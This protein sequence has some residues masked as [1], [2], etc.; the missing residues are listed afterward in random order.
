MSLPI[1]NRYFWREISFNIML[2][3]FGLLAMFSFFDLLQELDSLGKGHYGI[4]SM[5]TF[6]GLSIP[7][8]IY[9]VAPVAVLLGIVYTLGAMAGN[10]ELIVMRTSGISLQVIAKILLS[11]GLVFALVT[12]MIG[13]IIAPL[14]EKMAQR[15]RIQA[16]DSVI[17]QDFQS[18][19]WIKDGSSFVNVN[20]VLPDSSLVNIDIYDFDPQFHLRSISHAEKGHFADDH[21]KLL[22]VTQTLF[23]NE[24]AVQNNSVTSKFVK[25]AQWESL[26]RPE[27]LNVLLVLP[28]KMSAWNLYSFIQ[29]LHRNGQKSTR[30]QVALWSKLIYPLAC[31]VMVVLALPFGFL[32]QRAGGISAK[33]FSGILLGVVYQIMNRVFVHLGVLNDWSPLFSAIG[34]TLLFLFA[35]LGMLHYV[36]KR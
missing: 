12:F 3:L 23:N 29:H 10:S 27:L 9:E 22:N 25:Q 31:L 28:E 32:Q 15:I 21:W 20:T 11:I 14:S 2:V 16:T 35:G 13:E 19:L 8:H 1:L 30:Y 6:V 36:E 18:G 17:A 5:L 26:I 24:R 33:I 4:N 7:G 34:P